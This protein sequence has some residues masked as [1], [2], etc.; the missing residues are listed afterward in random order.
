MA[1]RS[2]QAPRGMGL[3]MRSAGDVVPLVKISEEFFS[4]AVVVLDEF[5]GQQ[6][7]ENVTSF[8][9][10]QLSPD[11]QLPIG[12]NTAQP[13]VLKGTGKGSCLMLVGRCTIKELE[14][15]TKFCYIL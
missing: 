10:Q 9:A 11:G 5:L 3:V 4:N 6:K 12:A 15:C 2:H 8:E 13:V 1:L 7:V 14:Y